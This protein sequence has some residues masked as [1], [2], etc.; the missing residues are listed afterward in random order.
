M[1]ASP[2]LA[3]GQMYVPGHAK[4]GPYIDKIVYDVLTQEDQRIIAIQ[5]GT[6]DLIDDQVDPSYLE[7]LVEAE[8]VEVYNMVRNG[9][10]LMEINCEKYPLNITAFRRAI[11]FAVDKEAISDDVWEGLSQPQD[12]MVPAT[13]IHT[14]EG[15]LPYTYYESN[16]ELANEIL[17]DAGFLDVD[18]DGI[19]EAP[20]GEDFDILVECA[21][22]SPQAIEIGEIFEEALLALD[23]DANSEPT[24]FYEYLTRLHY[25]GDYD[26]VFLGNSFN[27]FD[28][29]WLIY[30]Y[31]SA[32]AE[33]PFLNVV[34]FRNASFDSWI[35]QLQFGATYEEVHEAAIEMQRI[36]VY[37]C[38]EIICYENIQLYPYRTDRFENFQESVIDG[39]PGFWTN[40]KVHLTEDMDGPYGG[41][42][43][44]SN[45]EEIDTFNFMATSS[46]YAQQINNMM[47]DQ[48]MR[49]GADGH[50]VP[51]LAESW[52]L[53]THDDN[54]AIPEG[55]ARITFDLIQ[56]AT[57]TDGTPL[58]GE[59][60][61]FTLN[62]YND[63]AG[64]PYGPDLTEM[65]AAY[66]PTTYQV[67]VEFAS[68]SYWNLHRIGYKPIIPKHVFEST[69][70]D[71]WNEWNPTP[72]EQM[73]VTSGPFNVTEHIDGE[74]T[75][76]SY[77]PNYFFGLDRDAPITPPNGGSFNLTLALM[78]GAV[79]AVVIVVIGAYLLFR[80]E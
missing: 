80:R 24:D 23:I 19:R 79:G 61:A 75:E 41:T 35:P 30:N 25:H 9:Y 73:M 20:N 74:F 52:T 29:D 55:H 45:S 44:W 46:G 10:G 59:D 64:N 14:I 40:L 53:E 5:D 76:L 13:N 37:E 63:G 78:V 28:V 26:M 51:W 6:I 7:Q 69:E 49:V 43:T 62:Y 66:S 11:A 56:N 31:G 65:V 72:P 50:D 17:D 47:W 39:I 22:V 12:S 34:N 33:E 2:M 77:N 15:Q 32:Y 71:D 48:L 42:L 18:E 27:T 4:S 1:S 54:A 3:A 8:D 38:P 16:I 67:V 21:S 58:T 57:W 70:A 60:V 36:L 68:E